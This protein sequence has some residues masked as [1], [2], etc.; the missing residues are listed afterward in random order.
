MED[1][2]IIVFAQFYSKRSKVHFFDAKAVTF[3]TVDENPDHIL[4]ML[5]IPLFNS[6]P[7]Y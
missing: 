3:S 7:K 2:F 1:G 4:A 5:R 6:C